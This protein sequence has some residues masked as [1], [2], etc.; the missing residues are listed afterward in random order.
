MLADT[1]LLYAAH[2][3]RVAKVQ[4]GEQDRKSSAPKEPRS[5]EE[6]EA[7]EKCHQGS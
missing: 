1:P 7:M 2:Y 4:G 3:P 6:N 5:G